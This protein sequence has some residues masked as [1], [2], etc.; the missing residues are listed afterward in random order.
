MGDKVVHKMVP[1][2]AEKN[3]QTGNPEKALAA[4]K[5]GRPFTERKKTLTRST[6]WATE[7]HFANRQEEA[8]YEGCVDVE[9]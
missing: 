7:R 1:G 3:M 2:G 5:E 9:V 6:S 4:A 8:V